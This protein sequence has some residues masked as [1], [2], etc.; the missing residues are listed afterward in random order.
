MTFRPVSES[1]RAEME[2]QGT[3]P[4]LLRPGQPQEPA[5][6]VAWPTRAAVEARM[7]ALGREIT[8][9]QL[10]ATRAIASRQGAINELRLLLGEATGEVHPTGGQPATPPAASAAA[11]AQGGRA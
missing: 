7:V 3:S 5:E 4:R 1:E 2:A 8:Q 9:I 10:D 6:P 11:A